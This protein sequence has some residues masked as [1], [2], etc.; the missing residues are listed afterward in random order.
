TISA[1][2]VTVA[3]GTVYQMVPFHDCAMIGSCLVAYYDDNTQ[4]TQTDGDVR[5]RLFRPV[6]FGDRFESGNTTA[7]S[8][9]IP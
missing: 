7:W 1:G 9:T 4:G 8:S 5:A 2:P 3:D 6:V